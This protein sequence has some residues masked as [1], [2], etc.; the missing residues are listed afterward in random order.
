VLYVGTNGYTYSPPLIR[1]VYT[2]LK[3]YINAVADEK[4]PPGQTV[5][6]TLVRVL[7]RVIWRHVKERTG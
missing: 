7:D 6:L 4:L 3:E 1:P 5:A 2:Q